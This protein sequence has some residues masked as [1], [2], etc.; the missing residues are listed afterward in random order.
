VVSATGTLDAVTAVQV[1]SQ[2]GGIIQELGEN[3][4]TVDFNSSSKGQVLLE[5]QPRRDQHPDR[6]GQCDARAAQ[7][8]PRARRVS[9]E[10]AA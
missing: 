8:R 7:S 9:V 2:V 10:D 4:V 6:I 1:G 5:D 3:G